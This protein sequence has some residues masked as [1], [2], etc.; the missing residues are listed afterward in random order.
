MEGTFITGAAGVAV[1]VIV[2]QVDGVLEWIVLI[3][4]AAG[5]LSI[6][7]TKLV[8]PILKLGRRANAGIDLLLEMPAEFASVKST[9]ETHDQRLRVIESNSQPEV[10]AFV[11]REIEGA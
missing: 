6:I 11:R 5:A 1:A 2:N 8:Q 9:L 10:R 4:A 7:N 3:G